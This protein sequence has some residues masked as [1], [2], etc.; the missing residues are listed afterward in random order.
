LKYLLLLR[1]KTAANK[2]TL[3]TSSGL[4]KFPL[5]NSLRFPH[6]L[7]V[8]DGAFRDVSN[9]LVDH[10]RSKEYAEQRA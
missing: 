10:Q 6:Y 5:F 1:E 7:N 2:K 3:E 9:A 4:I 8:I